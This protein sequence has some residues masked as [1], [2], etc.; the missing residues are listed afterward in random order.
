MLTETRGLNR[1][2]TGEDG[3]MSFAG[4]SGYLL[5]DEEMEGGIKDSP[6]VLACAHGVK[7]ALFVR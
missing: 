6:V 4:R 2:R 5:R 7:V 3:D 1:N